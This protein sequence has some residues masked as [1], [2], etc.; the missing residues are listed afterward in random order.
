LVDFHLFVCS[1]FFVFLSLALVLGLGVEKDD[2]LAVKYYQMS[3]DQGYAAALSNLGYCYKHGQGVKE[4]KYE[5]VR[6]YGLGAD[7]NHATSL[8]NLGYCYQ[9]GYGVQKDLAEAVRLYKRSA[10]QGKCLP[11][12]LVSY[13]LTFLSCCCLP[14]SCRSLYCSE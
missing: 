3:A 11:L 14:L 4:D 13:I 12:V 10:D 9:H 6:L 2:I 8:N 7:Q 1:H 5:A